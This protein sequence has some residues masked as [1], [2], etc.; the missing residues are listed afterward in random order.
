MAIYIYQLHPTFA[1]VQTN[2]R[3]DMLCSGDIVYVKYQYD[4]I[5]FTW[6]VK[7]DQH[8]PLV[9]ITAP[10][11][12]RYYLT[13]NK[14]YYKK[15]MNSTAVI[16]KDGFIELQFVVSNTDYRTDGFPQHAVPI[17]EDLILNT[18]IQHILDCD[19]TN[20]GVYSIYVDSFNKQVYWV[21]VFYNY[22]GDHNVLMSNVFE[23]STWAAADIKTLETL[24]QLF[25]LGGISV[26]IQKTANYVLELYEYSI[27]YGGE[28]WI[29]CTSCGDNI[30]LNNKI[31]DLL[32]QKITANKLA[33]TTTYNTIMM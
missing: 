16:N 6:N 7:H 25:Y 5:C 22:E 4:S 10:A 12:K 23:I 17:P 3:P 33:A 28:Q 11:H 30:T 18:Y 13:Q 2:L 1:P 15:I 19:Q 32:A 24:F 8:Y 26:Y 14:S 9:L 21:H 27:V 31:C 29:I 20:K